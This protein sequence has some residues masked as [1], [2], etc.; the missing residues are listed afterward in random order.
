MFLYKQKRIEK[1]EKTIILI[2]LLLII[3]QL[4]TSDLSM[5]IFNL[6]CLNV[7]LSI[8]KNS[9]ENYISVG[10]SVYC[11]SSLDIPSDYTDLNQ[12]GMWT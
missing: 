8:V 9:I 7:K 5:F 12:F 2:P 4:L 1:A 10:L 11:L 6:A 3:P